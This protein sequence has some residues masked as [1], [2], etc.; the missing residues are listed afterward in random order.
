MR[1]GATGLLA[2]VL[3][4]VVACA[5]GTA[6]GRVGP[7][8]AI[9]RCAPDTFAVVHTYRYVLNRYNQ[10]NSRDSAQW[11]VFKAG[12]LT[13]RD[14]N[15]IRLVSQESVCARA[16]TVYTAATRD[17]AR[18]G[19][20]RVTVVQAGDRFIITDPFTPQ[21]G[22]EWAIQLIADRN[23]KVLIHLGR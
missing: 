11:S 3:A 15:A 1:L 4:L 12:Y 7:S 18:G 5:R 16:A 17:S 6:A 10:H 13:V 2:V 23:W 19:Q 21:M 9:S 22:G 8:A 14:T 20:R